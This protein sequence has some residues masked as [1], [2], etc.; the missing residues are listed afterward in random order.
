MVLP[1]QADGLHA[2]LSVAL[3][4][5]G[6][7]WINEL[8]RAQRAEELRA[9][10]EKALRDSKNQP[11][12]AEFRIERFDLLW[13]P[14]VSASLETMRIDSVVVG[15]PHC[16]KCAVPLG[17]A[18]KEWACARC[19]A[20]HPESVTDTMAT[21]SVAQ[22]AVKYFQERRP[23]YRVAVKGLKPSA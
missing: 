22:Q 3:S 15:V 11:E 12:R 7:L 21:D 20:R 10:A 6:I 1:F 2:G 17:L 18:G 14:V 5:V 19:S 13:Y 8:K 9:K 23:G 4:L 16:G